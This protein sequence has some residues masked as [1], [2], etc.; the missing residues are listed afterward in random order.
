MRGRLLLSLGVATV[1]L[2]SPIGALARH[3]GGHGGG[4]PGY[5]GYHDHDSYPGMPLVAAG[6]GYAGYGYGFPFF[7]GGPVFY[8]YYPTI[9]APGVVMPQIGQVPPPMLV[10]G[11]V[12]AAPPLRRVESI[13]WERGGG[14][15][16]QISTRRPARVSDPKRAAQVLTFG[17]RLFRAGNIKRAEERYQQALAAAP[18]QAAPHIRLA[19]IALTRGNYAEA[20]DRFR[21]AET[22]EPGW[23]ATA[24][25]VQSLY[26]EPSDFSAPIRKLESHLQAHPNDR[27]AWL[28]LGAQ[29]FL[30]GRT[31]RAA[32]VFLRLDDPHRQPDVALA[33]FLLAIDHSAPPAAARPGDANRASIPSPRPDPGRPAREHQ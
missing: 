24:P 6:G 33:A 26:G 19:Q 32:D 4:H 30:S 5:T 28:V 18:S 31:R 16:R 13:P 3:G 11:P 10:R 14:E 2:A 15:T 29:W 27:D 9:V 1:L 8:T 23:I 7:V 22:A 25:D 20:A 21:D 17:D 12:A